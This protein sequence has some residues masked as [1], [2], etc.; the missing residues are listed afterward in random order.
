MRAAIHIGKGC[1]SCRGVGD[2]EFANPVGGE[3][4][5]RGENA[6]TSGAPERLGRAPSG[7]FAGYARRRVRIRSGVLMQTPV[8]KDGGSMRARRSCAHSPPS[9]T[10]QS[11][12]V[13]DGPANTTANIQGV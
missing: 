2:L 7:G 10:P 11:L 12:Q 8:S 4:G 6:M 13:H 9:R 3:S 5:D 1:G